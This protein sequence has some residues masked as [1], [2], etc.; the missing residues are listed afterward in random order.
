ML[1]RRCM[2]LSSTTALNMIGCADVF[3][4]LLADEVVALGNL[5]GRLVTMCDDVG[6][7]FVA[8]KAEALTQR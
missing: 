7:G 6:A 3:P 5:S 1:D 8:G 4:E 2:Y